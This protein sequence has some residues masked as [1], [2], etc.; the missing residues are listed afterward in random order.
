MG[1]RS[2]GTRLK[3]LINDMT[4]PDDNTIL[5]IR[6]VEKLCLIIFK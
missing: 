3:K 4:I 1:R 6:H 5:L 2:L